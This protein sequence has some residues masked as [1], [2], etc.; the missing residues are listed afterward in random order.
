MKGPR[1][2][3]LWLS[4]AAAIWGSMYV[5]SKIVLATIPP[6]M[7]VWLRYGVALVTLLAAAMLVRASWR[8][9]RRDWWRVAQIGVVGYGVSISAQFIGT[10]LATAQLGSLIT[11]GTPAFMVIFA[12]L[13]LRERI[14]LSKIGAI[15]L[16]TMGVLLI[17]GMGVST[18]HVRVGELILGIAALSW[19][20]MSVLVKTLPSMYSS[21]TV[22]LY[23]IAIA[24]CLMTPL[25]FTQ[26]SWS[27]LVTVMTYQPRLIGYVAYLGAVSTAVAFFL[28]N[29]GLQ[30]VE[31]GIGGLYLF[32][33]PVVG[34]ILGWFW[35]GERFGWAFI[36]GAMLI[37][38]G[39]F[40][41]L[42]A[43]NRLLK[44]ADADPLGW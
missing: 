12:Y 41:A 29:Y 44:Q 10:K 19:A 43:E 36:G 14:T 23:A 3:A 13:L 21:L 16:A 39:V 17:V 33:Q 26:M 40:L 34:G 30:Q 7:L 31:A 35:L 18:P 2:G 8:I 38:F 42:R 1:W 9:A 5:V 25:A 15:V 6:L 27:H 24:F 11:A 32:F 20:W 37:G 28:W 22:T 4:M